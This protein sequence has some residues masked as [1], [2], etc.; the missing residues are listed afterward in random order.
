MAKEFAR[1]YLSIAD[2]T[3]F[4]DLSVDAQWLY[5]RVLVPDPSL[6]Y[7]GAAD[8]RPDGSRTR[9]RTSS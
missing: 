8:W 6:S 9:L 5:Q 3:D 1:T 7:A 4:E 2:D